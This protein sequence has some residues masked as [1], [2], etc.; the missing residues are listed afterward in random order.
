M[1]RNLRF[2]FP[3][4]SLRVGEFGVLRT[5]EASLETSVD[6]CLAP[7]AIDRLITDAVL[8]GD[9]RHGLLIGLPQDPHHLVFRES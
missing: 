4:T 3:D 2:E 9:L 8:L 6:S 7:P 1:D 5:R